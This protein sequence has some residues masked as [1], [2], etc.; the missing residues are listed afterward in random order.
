M[1]AATATVYPSPSCCG[2][3]QNSELA[4]PQFS[5]RFKTAFLNP[6]AATV[7]CRNASKMGSDQGQRPM[8]ALVPSPSEMCQAKPVGNLSGTLF[9]G[10]G[11]LSNF[12]MVFKA[13][14][15]VDAPGAY[16]IVLSADDGWIFSVGTRV[17]GT[18]QPNRVSGPMV[19][20]PP[21]SPGKGYAVMGAMNTIATAAPPVVVNFPAAG[22]YPVEIDYTECCGD[23][24]NLR[25]SSS[26]LAPLQPKV[27]PRKNRTCTPKGK[28]KPK[29]RGR[30]KKK[31]ATKRRGRTKGK[32]GAACRK[33]PVNT[34]N[35]GFTVV[36][37]PD[38]SVPSNGIPFD[39]ERSYCSCVPTIGRL[40]QG[41]T[42]S[43][44]T[45]L[46][47]VDDGDIEL[48]T[49]AGQV[50]DYSQAD[51]GT[52]ST[53]GNASVLT[54]TPTGYQLVTPDQVTWTFDQFGKAQSEKD[55]NGNGLVFAH[56]VNGN[57]TG[58]TDAS[59]H[60]I[61]LAY[62]GTGHIISISGA[63]M[64]V[65]YGYTNGLLTSV[66]DPAGL[67]TSYTYDAA[68]RI[69]TVVDGNGN[70]E[71]QNVYDD[72]TGRVVSQT[73]ALGRTTTFGWDE[74]AQT[75]T[76]T[77]ARGKVW[78]DVY[79]NGVL[80][81]ETSPSPSIA[82][83]GTYTVTNGNS[84][85]CV[86]NQFSQTADGT[87]VWQWDCNWGLA[88]RWV[89]AATDNGYYQVQNSQV[90]S[91]VWDV[92]NASPDDGAPIV[93]FGY[94]GGTDKQWKPVLE[95]TGA[96]HF[97]NRGSGK[98]LEVPGAALD[99][100]YQLDQATCNGSAAQSW[101]VSLPSQQGTGTTQYGYDA[102][103]NLSYV[104]APN[105]AQTQMVY[106]DAGNL[107]KMIAP[108]SLNSA[109]KTFSYDAQNNVT[110]VT[111][112]KGTVTVYTYDA[113]GDQT[114]T[115]VNGQLVSSATYDG[116]GN[117]LTS[118]DGNG[119]T[120][121]YTY[122]G[123]GSLASETDPLGNTT[124]YSYDP[125]GD[126]LSETDPLGKTT[127][128]AYDADGNLLTTTDP[129][130]RTTTH[131]YDG[132]GNLLT[133]TDPL[134]RTTTKAYDAAGQLVKVTSPDPDGA[135]PLPA[136]VTTYAYDGVGNQ[137]AQTD[138][139]GHTTTST[140]DAANQLVATMTPMG[141]KSSTT[142]DANG[143]AVG[144]TD[145][146]GNLSGADPNAFTTTSTYDDA[147][148]LVST[149]DA[150]GHTTSYGYN[151]VGQQTT[152][153]DGNGHTTTT[154]YDAQGRA[155]SVTD[156]LGNATSSGYDAA[157][158]R[159]TQTDALGNVTHDAYDAANRLVSTTT[160]L[161]EVTTYAYDAD[162]HQ[163]KV[164]DPLGHS[165]VTA[166]D[167]AGQVL[168]T[169]DPL[170]H[171]TSFTYD[172]NGEQLTSTD[173][174]GHRTTLAYDALGRVTQ[175]TAPDG[176]VT[177]NAYDASGSLVSRTDANGHAT[178]F[179]YDADGRRTTTTN[180]LGHTWTV[181][182][183]A[184]GDKISSTNP[185]GD[186][187]TYV[188]D[189]AGELTSDS[190]RGTY[191]YDQA[192]NPLTAGGETFVY[193][194]A[195]RRTTYSEDPG[196][197][198]ASSATEGVTYTLDAAGNIT[199]RAYADGR[200]VDYSYDAD[201]RLLSVSSATDGTGPQARYVYDAAGRLVSTV[202]ANGY[203]ET[204]SY[205]NADRLLE[206]KNASS[207]GVLS[208]FVTTYDPVGN[209]LKVTRSGATSSVTTYLYDANDRLTDTCFTARCSPS[210]GFH[211]AYDKVGNQ[212]TETR[213]AKTIAYGYDA[214]D[215][216][217]SQ[218]V[219][220]NTGPK[221]T[222]FSYDGNGNLAFDG[223]KYYEYN[224]DNQLTV[225]S[226]LQ[227][228]QVYWQSYDADGNRTATIVGRGKS[229]VNEVHFY[230]P[231]FAVP[232]LEHDV[233]LNGT[234]IR[235]YLYGNGRIAM[236]SAGAVANPY[237]YHYDQLGSVANMTSASGATQWTEA[238]DPFGQKRSETKNDAAAP[239]NVM[240]FV[241]EQLDGATDLYFLRARSYDPTVGR[242]TSTDPAAGES[243]PASSPYAYASDRPVLL[244]DPTGMTTKKPKAQVCAAGASST[245]GGFGSPDV[246]RTPNGPADNVEHCKD[247]NAL[248]GDAGSWA[249]PYPLPQTV[250]GGYS[251]DQGVDYSPGDPV[252]AIAPGRIYAMTGFGVYEALDTPYVSPSNH[253]YWSVYYAEEPALKGIHLGHVAA[254][255]PVIDKGND[256]I[257]FAQKG[258]AELHGTCVGVR[259][260]NGTSGPCGPLIAHKIPHWTKSTQEG[261]EFSD[262]LYRIQGTLYPSLGSNPPRECK[263]MVDY[264]G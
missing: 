200:S 25:V 232:Q 104:T 8:L 111:D 212:L 78:R 23:G 145:A 33:D 118:T 114:S 60:V 9:A 154:A 177:T 10:S 48:H 18:E 57:L 170:G 227:H 7:G 61:T 32:T 240:K 109:T 157:G 169:T 194:A 81:S 144:Q 218:V 102:D 62:D 187:R 1:K 126:L 250:T 132:E 156:A 64:T 180:A 261:C 249:L 238:Y 123:G 233:D 5:Q 172:A 147:G 55:A 134:G 203:T 236:A 262:L 215:E 159:V 73:D 40:G 26:S 94:D 79:E 139:A 226:N 84:N 148:R 149:Q 66:T 209:P 53:D 223:A 254:G 193:D 72:T 252:R 141:E 260:D 39:F 119:H 21:S 222:S 101:Y 257:G 220:T 98:C 162:G 27:D 184:A 87:V 85:K 113:L 83:G 88:Q 188:Y 77:D 253:T 138:V 24:E 120:T 217:L 256:E 206:V 246:P 110:S 28:P 242:F 121:T 158:N 224:F 125:Q 176:G 15:V 201:G 46:S 192:G 160:P 82:D 91:E 179:A 219:T 163:T 198:G 71:I 213:P 12:Q 3:F 89:F 197:S 133:T 115:K 164:T 107:T 171:A 150:A 237:Y 80:A 14:L 264:N 153:T 22:T 230:D 124:S 167:A 228:K 63:G 75:A 19:N 142:Y 67:T 16:T 54:T 105:G 161:G 52:W 34:F 259:R 20:A 103:T 216:L 247:A 108:D 225:V 17:K 255:T 70:T 90:S 35:G 199:R 97:V 50:F 128:Y 137:V 181:V 168:S 263:W 151:A 51:D 131:T 229:A 235:S 204:R 155:T 106:D 130:G 174:N 205:D 95:S 59:G 116:S 99:R 127:T 96:Y 152:V 214:A 178:T 36:D 207:G 140:Y 93:L 196:G 210:A 189:G 208:D 185:N 41:W 166:Y 186:T 100:G 258:L 183:D 135:G 44:D 58:V 234:L 4:S 244:V 56:D 146:R 6:D 2:V 43:Y 122:D 129:L 117:Q 239:E 11:S 173:S 251:I 136:P 191:T 231:S 65:Q 211:W 195:N 37:Q 38:L 92:Q 165:T 86:D 243:G 190:A 42:D 202:L 30:T 31:A 175:T 245:G 68:G 49:D 74:A 76:I 248:A 45:S 29:A 221:T 241:G 182:Y 47:V 13:K 143:N 112:A 69:T